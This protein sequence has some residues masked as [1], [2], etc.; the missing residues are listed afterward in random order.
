M[1]LHLSDVRGF[2]GGREVYTSFGPAGH[3]PL[4]GRLLLVG[5]FGVDYGAE[6]FCQVHDVEPN[7]PVVDV[8]GVHG[9]HPA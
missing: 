6:G 4:G 3:L 1:G 5:A 2:A 9:Y 8:P 7:G